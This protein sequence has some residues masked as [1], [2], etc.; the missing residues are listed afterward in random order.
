MVGSALSPTT[1]LKVDETGANEKVIGYAL[2]ATTGA[3]EL[4]KVLF[5]G[6][7]GFSGNKDS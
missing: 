6:L 3:D 7:N 2:E 4:K 5:D 1:A